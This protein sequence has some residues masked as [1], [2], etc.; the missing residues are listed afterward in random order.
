MYRDAD[1]A[2]LV[3]DGPGDGLADPP[4][5][6]GGELIPPRIVEL[7]D[8]PN[9]ANVPLLGEIEERHSVRGI[10]LGDRDHEAQVCLDQPLLGEVVIALYPPQ[11]LDR[12]RAGP[13][14]IGPSDLL[15]PNALV[16]QL[17]LRVQLVLADP[18]HGVNHEAEPLLVEPVRG[19]DGGKQLGGEPSRLYPH[20][21]V[22]L[23]GGGKER[24]LAD[25]L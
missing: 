12:L 22:D 17:V 11:E 6:V 8:R 14:P 20:G 13:R 4:R 1:R 19:V 25:V 7:L 5:G 18:E 2:G 23:L 10:P 24:D 3:G 21:Q 9:E 16:L 15:E